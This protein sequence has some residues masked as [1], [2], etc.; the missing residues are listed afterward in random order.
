MHAFVG[1]CDGRPTLY[2]TRRLVDCH[3][4]CLR[5]TFVY[6]LRS[7]SCEYHIALSPVEQH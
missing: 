6:D 2:Q 7:T 5:L 4:C 1:V 3:M